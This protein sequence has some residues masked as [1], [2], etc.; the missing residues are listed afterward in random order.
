M[1]IFKHY[2]ISLLKNVSNEDLVALCELLSTKIAKPKKRLYE[3][4]G[5]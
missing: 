3:T 2:F 1:E 5:R 4:L